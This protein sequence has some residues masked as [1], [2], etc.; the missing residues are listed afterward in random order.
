MNNIKIGSS[1]SS[2]PNWAADRTLENDSFIALIES[3]VNI[4][5]TVH[6]LQQVKDMLLFLILYIKVGKLYKGETS[7][8]I[9]STFVYFGHTFTG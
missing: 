7:L 5:L 6:L 8:Y 9:S 1:S 2:W 4:M 3:A